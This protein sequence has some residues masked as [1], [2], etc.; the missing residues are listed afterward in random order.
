MDVLQDMIGRRG[1][2]CRMCGVVWME[3]FR[4]YWWEWDVRVR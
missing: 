1:I 2:G 4:C 3:D